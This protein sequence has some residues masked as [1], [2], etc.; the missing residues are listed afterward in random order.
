M[1][2]LDEF[3]N[4]MVE[5]NA[6][7]LH[8]SSD[9][10]PMFRIS[11]TIDPIREEVFSPQTV[12]ELIYEIIPERNRIEFEECHDTDFA[13]ELGDEARFRCNVFSDRKGIGGVFRLIPSEILSFE[14]LGLP[15]PIKKFCFLTK[16]LVLVTGP[17]GSGKST[18]LAAIIDFI[19]DNRDDHVIT[20]EDPVEFIHPNKKCLINQREVHSHT[21]SFQ[22]ALRAALREDPD[23]VLVGEMRDLETVMTA[24]ETAETGHLVFGTLHTTTSH[25][26]VERL[27]NQ[28][29]A[30]QQAQVRVALA[31]TLKGVVAQTLLKKKTGGRVAAIELLVGS[32][33]LSA[34]IREG[35]IHQIPMII[36]TGRKQGMRSLNDSLLDLL[37]QDIIEPIDAYQNAVEKTDLIKR[38]AS[39]PNVRSPRGAPWT[40]D[41]LVAA[42]S[43]PSKGS[44][45]GNGSAPTP[46]RPPG[47]PPPPPN[48]PPPPPLPAAVAR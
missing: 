17:T 16:G 32:H 29:P 30:G 48:V 15:E 42:S 37:G 24:L 10:Q 45:N 9:C 7:D 28:F 19:N 44:S 1:A 41:E 43:G 11:G 38:M 26:T 2:R 35:K 20:I 31:E 46:P 4:L 8:L 47:A 25:G 22:R 13:Y 5:K 6:S 34:N 3:F 23:I 21:Q 39:L 18:T 33:A 12:K 14:K 36:Q 27:I 40:E